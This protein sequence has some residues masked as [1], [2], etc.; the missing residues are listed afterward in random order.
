[1][2]I[3]KHSKTY[4]KYLGS[5]CCFGFP[6]QPAPKT[7]ILRPRENDD[8][9]KEL[10][11]MTILTTLLLNEPAIAS[12]SLEQILAWCELTIDEYKQCLHM[13]DPVQ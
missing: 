11:A 13:T 6:K 5:N 3:K 4:V 1:M 7:I 12:L 8:P 9:D 2:H 10:A